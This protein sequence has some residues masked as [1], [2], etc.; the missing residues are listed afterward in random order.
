MRTKPKKRWNDLSSGAR[1][2][3]IAAGSVQI[4]LFFTAQRDLR[5]R[6]ADQ[7]NGSKR[8]WTA[9]SFVNF[10]GPIAYLTVGRR[11]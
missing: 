1:G 9:L 8:A 3:I 2:A 5:R 7:I 6:P 10:I 11:R 4:G